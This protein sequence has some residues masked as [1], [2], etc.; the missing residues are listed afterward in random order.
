M[1]CKTIGIA[2]QND[3]FCTPKRP[4]LHTKTTAFAKTLLAI[5]CTLPTKTP[6]TT[7][8]QSLIAAHIISRFLNRCNIF[9]DKSD[10]LW[11]Q[12][13]LY[14]HKTISFDDKLSNGKKITSTILHAVVVP[15]IIIRYPVFLPILWFILGHIARY[16]PSKKPQNRRK[17]QAQNCGTYSFTIA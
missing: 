4:L 14:H 8:Y 16:A 7:Y 13:T 11:L 5:F 17:I 15:T 9:S 2:L 3:R 6:Q 12:N 1:R 10:R